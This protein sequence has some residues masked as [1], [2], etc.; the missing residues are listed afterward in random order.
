LRI[1]KSCGNAAGASSNTGGRALT[2]S[3]RR[4]SVG[5]IL[6]LLLGVSLFLWGAIAKMAI[7][8]VRLIQAPVG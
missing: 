2:Q 4:W 5:Q 7:V 1:G 8:V 6:L 3:E